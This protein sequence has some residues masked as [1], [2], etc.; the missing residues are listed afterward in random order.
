MAVNVENINKLIKWLEQDLE[1]NNGEHF[2]MNRWVT[3]LTTGLTAS[4]YEFCKTAFCLGGSCYILAE[5]EKGLTPKEINLAVTGEYFLE[6]G[7]N[8]LGIN[9][10]EAYNLFYM[11]DCTIGTTTFDYLPQK[12]RLQA[13]IN[14]LENLRDSGKVDWDEALASAGVE[15][16]LE[17]DDDDDY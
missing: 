6:Y 14:V 16:P 7:A 17:D 2:L 8:Y 3:D 13:A 12:K 15:L 11:H 10:P 1:K 4:R 9:K 5:T